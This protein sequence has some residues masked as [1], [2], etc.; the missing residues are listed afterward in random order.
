MCQNEKRLINK[1]CDFQQNTREHGNEFKIRRI[2]LGIYLYALW[3][4]IPEAKQSGMSGSLGITRLQKILE[5]KCFWPS[6]QE[7][8]NTGIFMGRGM[9]SPFYSAQINLAVS[10]QVQDPSVKE[11]GVL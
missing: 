5:R 4:K 11:R 9:N 6:L 1:G 2:D 3:V 8:A 10:A 7:K